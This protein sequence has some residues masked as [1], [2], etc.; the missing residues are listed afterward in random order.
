MNDQG[1][2]TMSGGDLHGSAVG[3]N[4]GTINNYY[5]TPPESAKPDPF[6][7]AQALF[8]AMPLDHVPA[9]APLPHGSRILFSPNQTFAGRVDE[10]L[11][12]ARTL[13]TQRTTA[14]ATGIGGIGKTTLANEFA[15]R[16]GQYFMGGVFWLSF[17]S[18]DNVHAEIAACGAKRHLD[19]HPEFEKLNLVDQ[20]G[21]VQKHWA[22]S[23]PCLLIF[24]N[25]EA[26]DLLKF[27]PPTGEARVLITS[28][29]RQWNQTYGIQLIE[30]GKLNRADSV[31]MLDKY[32]F[33]ATADERAMLAATLD[34]LPLALHLAASYIANERMTVAE[35]LA[36]LAAVSLLEH[37]SLKPSE[38]GIYATFALSYD[39]LDPN[40]AVDA[41]AMQLLARAACF[42]H[43]EPLP[44]DLLK[45][46]LEAE[47]KIIR[48]ALAR[49][50]NALGLLEPEGDNLRLHRLLAHFVQQH[51]NDDTAQTAVE[52]VM[53]T[54]SYE[55]NATGIPSKLQPL[56]THLRWMTAQAL[57]REDD[58]AATLATN[59]GYHLKAMGEYAAARP[60][61]ER[62]LAIRETVLGADHPDTAQS[63]N[64]L[65]ALLD[66]MGEYAAARPL[67]ERALAICE[68]VLGADHPDT[69]G[70]L[71]NLAWLCYNEGDV[72]Q[73]IAYMRRALEIF[74]RFLGHEHPNTRTV[75]GNVE[76]LEN[77]GK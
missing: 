46:T 54:V 56:Q 31:A 41:C 34:D 62:A 67:Y 39:K 70:R 65:A 74:E 3:K 23:P 63:L 9:V 2:M 36:E 20:F 57:Q 66:D 49:L 48:K 6:V 27:V 53:R 37:E 71:N 45:R 72:A 14:I 51:P 22:E 30:L 25:C 73:A 69:A 11:T 60:L 24:D 1:N 16:Y 29:R 28:R 52:Q 33:K 64:N 44:S 18:P 7:A 12:L 4:D 61:Y 38:R 59:L 5:G 77:V 50:T 10:L 47:P 68:T 58:H 15:H 55:L 76:Y 43:G 21:L 32:R 40:D 8:A 42:A 26:D 75:R 13:A 19:L 17:A 35:Y